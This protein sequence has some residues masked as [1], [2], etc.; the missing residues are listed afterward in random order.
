MSSKLCVFSLNGAQK[1]KNKQTAV[2]REHKKE[3]K[4]ENEQHN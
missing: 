3:K 4:K 1:G 2:K